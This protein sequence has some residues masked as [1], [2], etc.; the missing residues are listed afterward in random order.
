VF[1][2]LALGPAYLILAAPAEAPT[3]APQAATLP[4]ETCTYDAG[5]NIR[6]C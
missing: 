3:G 2:I 6:S 4:A 1:L 5:T